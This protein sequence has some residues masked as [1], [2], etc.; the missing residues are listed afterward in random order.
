MGV[1]PKI[2]VSMKGIVYD[3]ADAEALAEFYH[4]LLGWK[5]TY[6]GNGWASLT[7]P[8]GMVLAFQTVDGYMQPVW[9]WQ[10]GEQ[11]QMLHLDFRVDNLEKAVEYA[12]SCGATI[13][14]MQ[15]YNDSCTLIDPAGHTFCLD[16]GQF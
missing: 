7:A 6:S 2:E 13:A 12:V 4:T 15:F 1:Y 9:P 16:T 10:Q 8:D 3:S 14:N 5:K 11:G